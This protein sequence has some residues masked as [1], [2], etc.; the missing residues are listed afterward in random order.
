MHRFRRAFRTTLRWAALLAVLAT[1]LASC[2][3]GDGIDRAEAVR[4]VVEE[5]GGALSVEQAE[6]YVDRVL[7]DVGASVLR[8]GATVPPEQVGTITAIRVDCIGVSNLA[9]KQPSLDGTDDTSVAGAGLPKRFGDD[10]ALD[11]LWSSCA[12]GVGADCDTLFDEAPSGS[13]YE[14]FAATCGDRTREL[15]CADVYPSPGV[16]LPSPAQ[17]TTTVPPSVP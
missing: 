12:E 14:R 7:D 11:A 8:P 16:T 15:R 2:S 6:C 3:S 13:D 1:A 4:T 17:P 5:S 10:P 9:S